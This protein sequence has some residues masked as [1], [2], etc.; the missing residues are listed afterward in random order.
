MPLNKLVHELAKLPAVGE[1]TALRL[2]LHIL[3][4]PAEYAQTLAKALQETIGSTRFCEGCGHLSSGARC[5][6]CRDPNRD[7]TIICV[8]EDVADLMAIEKTQSFCGHYHVLHG[9]L[10]PIDGI[11]PDQLRIKELL[12]RFAAPEPPTEIILATNP[13]VNGDATALYLSRLLKQR[14]VSVTRLASGLPIGGHIE[15]IDQSTLA[16]AFERRAAF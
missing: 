11:G 6:I 4:Q 13:D 14:G 1:K 9:S 5:S 2:A 8:V 15:Y 16:R 3:R 7:S 12:A 10:S